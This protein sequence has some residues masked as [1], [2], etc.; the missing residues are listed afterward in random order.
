MKQKYGD[1]DEE[2]RKLMMELIGAKEIQKTSKVK[3]KQENVQYYTG[4]KSN[5]QKDGKNK[6][7]QQ[8][9]QNKQNQQNKQNSKNNQNKN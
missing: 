6:N 5:D 7:K 1:Q 3:K 9:K 8:N 4:D 2:D